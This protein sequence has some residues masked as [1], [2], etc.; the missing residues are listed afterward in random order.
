MNKN[1]L[2]IQLKAHNIPSDGTSISTGTKLM[3]ML[4]HTK[5]YQLKFYNFSNATKEIAKSTREISPI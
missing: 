2:N 3:V 4:L 1:K 5:N